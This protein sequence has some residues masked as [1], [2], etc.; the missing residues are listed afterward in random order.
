MTMRKDLEKRGQ[1]RQKNRN[2]WAGRDISKKA[3]SLACVMP[4][5][6]QPTT[7]NGNLVQMWTENIPVNIKMVA[8]QFRI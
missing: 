2:F 7:R 8:G 5:R 3:A 1:P 6:T 4:L